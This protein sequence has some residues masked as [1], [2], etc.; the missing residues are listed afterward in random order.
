M[1][2]PMTMTTTRYRLLQWMMIAIVAGTML[3]VVGGGGMV[4]RRHGDTAAEGLVVATHDS[5]EEENY[6]E[7]DYDDA[8]YF[9]HTAV[10]YVWWGP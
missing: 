6:D 9:C 2:L 7:Y 3:L 5:T 8:P 4:W 10:G 1:F